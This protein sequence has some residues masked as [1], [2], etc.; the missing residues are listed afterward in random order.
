VLKVRVRVRVRVRFMVGVGLGLG[1]GLRLRLR[2]RARL[3][4]GLGHA[5][6]RHGPRRAVESGDGGLGVLGLR[7]GHEAV[8]WAGKYVGQSVGRQASK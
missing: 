4:V 7:E 6:A 2:L 3:R 1:L 8:A 5:T